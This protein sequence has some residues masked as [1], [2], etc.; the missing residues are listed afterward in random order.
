MGA[1]IDIAENVDAALQDL[2][3][4]VGDV[5]DQAVA[6]ALA[7]GI[8]GVAELAGVDPV[9]ALGAVNAGIG[10]AENVDAAL[11]D[12]GGMVGDV[13]ESA[14][15][16]VVA[17]GVAG[18][19]AEAV[20]MGE[21]GQAVTLGAAGD[22]GNFM[23]AGE[24]RLGSITIGDPH[25][26]AAFWQQQSLPDDCAVMAQVSLLRQFDVNISE[27][28]AV[29]EC[30]SMGW[31]GPGGTMPDDVGNLMDLHGVTT[32][33]VHNAT[34]ADLAYELQQGHGVIV[35][36]KAEELWDSGPLAD[37]RQ[38][39]CDAFGL[40]NSTFNPANHA[41]VITGID[42]TD[43]GNPQVFIN[44][45]GTPDGCRHPYPIGQFMDAWANSDFHYTATNEA[46]PRNN[47]TMGDIG[48]L[49]M[50]KWI[51]DSTDGIASLS[52]TGDTV[53]GLDAGVLAG[54]IFED[55]FSDSSYIRNI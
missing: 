16:G 52:G 26:Q 31:Y 34:I 35:G 47:A 13:A 3:D 45:P 29:Y 4:M 19:V 38:W 27:E 33:D 15:A 14:V 24:D 8:A 23:D 43:P 42:V 32:H 5:A 30:A 20:G 11:Q 41:V 9:E 46:I 12:L 1:C 49:D 21:A 48:L 17:E 54:E 10:I 2:G 53:A 22:V 50:G 18:L 36:V 39:I 6:G 55:L 40:D 51:G 44:D 37:L 28:Q 25:S 7:D